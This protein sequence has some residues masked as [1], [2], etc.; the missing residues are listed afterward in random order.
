VAKVLGD[1]FNC[2]G[3]Y[4]DAPAGGC[5]ELRF[6]AAGDPGMEGAFKTPGLR[7]V[8]RR[9]PY[10]HAGQFASLEEVVAHYRRSPPAA[11]GHSELAHRGQGHAERPPV[12]LSDD[13]AR[14]LVAF[15]ASLSSSV[16]QFGDPGP[17][18]R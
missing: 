10:M 17:Q 9:A 14:D 3:P 13:E 8:A 7:D 18:Q 2:L 16:R 12:R 6:I 15:L 11:V 1:E 5:Q 4:S